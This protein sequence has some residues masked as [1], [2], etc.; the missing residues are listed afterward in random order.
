MNDI[1]IKPNNKNNLNQQHA[2]KHKLTHKYKN[3]SG[4]EK[5]K[6]P[7]NANNII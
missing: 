3:K 1:I 6:L 5:L 4:V 7:T 2:K